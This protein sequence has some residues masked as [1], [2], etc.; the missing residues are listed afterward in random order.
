MTAKGTTNQIID[1]TDT[2]VAVF[3]TGMEVTQR[4]VMRNVTRFIRQIETDSQ[5][6]I[7]ISTGNLKTIRGI[8]GEISNLIVD[9]PYMNRVGEYLGNF[10]K[11]KGVTDNL[12][13]GLSEFESSSQLFKNILSINVRLT[14]NS[15]SKT[16]IN[17]NVIQPVINIITKGVTSGSSIMDMEDS[18]R[19]QILGDNERLGGLERYTKQITRD[20]LNQYSRNYNEAI[21]VDLGMDWYYYSGSKIDD[22]RSYCLERAGKYFHKKEVEQV[23]SRW[24]GMIPGTNSSSIFINAGGYNCRHLY[25]PV[26]IDVV[27]QSVVERNQSSGNYQR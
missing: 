12:F 24:A 17:H 1:I 3:N 20:A 11:I 2:A 22:T 8:K 18:L 19:L 27:P 9:K 7:I 21:S 6:G 26:L 13:E 23:P 10:S 16:G 15:L 25:M 5:G 4:N 14:K